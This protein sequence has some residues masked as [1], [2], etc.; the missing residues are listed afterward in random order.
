MS[1]NEKVQKGGILNWVFKYINYL[2]K[3]LLS[4]CLK[5]ESD[6]VDHDGSAVGAEGEFVKIHFNYLR[7]FVC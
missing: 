5:I 7:A 2:N 1:A 3:M 6:W 4:I